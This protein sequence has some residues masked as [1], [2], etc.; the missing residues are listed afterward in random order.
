MRRT[1]NDPLRAVSG[2]TSTWPPKEIGSEELPASLTYAPQPSPQPLPLCA[3][4]CVL[5]SCPA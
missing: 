5:P 1:S 2:I 3:P 4:Q